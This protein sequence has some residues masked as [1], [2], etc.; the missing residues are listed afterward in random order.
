MSR[1]DRLRIATC[2][3]HRPESAWLNDALESLGHD[4]APLSELAGRVDAVV[5]HDPDACGPVGLQQLRAAG[6][7]VLLR[8]YGDPERLDAHRAIAPFCD[9]TLTSG[10]ADCVHQYRQAGARALTFLPASPPS[11][12]GAPAFDGSRPID[13][14]F[15]GRLDGPERRHRRRLLDRAAGHWRVH[16][17]SDREREDAAALDALHRQSKLALHWDRLSLNRD[18]ITR[19]APG[20]R[21]FAGPAAGC[22]LLTQLAAWMPQCYDVAEEVAGFADADHALDVAAEYLGD[23]D[24]RASTAATGRER[25]L[26]THTYRH[27]AADLVALIRGHVPLRL[28]VLSLGPWYQRIQLPGGVSTSLL[29]MSNEARWQ[30]LEPHLPDVSGRQ[31]VDFGCNAGFFSLKCLERGAARAVAIDR[32]AL[33]CCQARFVFD[34]LGVTA[35]RV[36]HGDID[37]LADDPAELVL[38]LAVLHHHDDIEPLLRA[39]VVRSPRLV[40]EWHVR[41]RPFHHSIEHVMVVLRS[42]GYDAAVC[43]GGPRPIVLAGPKVPYGT[44]DET[45]L[46]QDVIAPRDA[47]A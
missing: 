32:S 27:R 24:R 30:R 45:G 22:V 12:T 46:R 20:T 35:T 41:E 6:S 4:V 14:L 8:A 28:Q 23:A 17:A 39:A 10:F 25:C 26:A 31:V 36:V 16:V 11:L 3:E 43:E 47:I 7:T 29:T 2:G 34:T 19:G 13:L 9:F 33:A 5:V 15:A 42:L 44:T 18:G 38:M 1:T 40:L 21:P 37:R